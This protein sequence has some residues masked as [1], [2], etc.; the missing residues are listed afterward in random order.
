MACD[1]TVSLDDEGKVSHWHH[2]PSGEQVT[3]RSYSGRGNL[4]FEVSFRS[5]EAGTLAP[6]VWAVATDDKGIFFFPVIYYRER[7]EVVPE[8]VEVVRE[9]QRP[10]MA[11]PSGDMAD[12]LAALKAHLGENAVISMSDKRSQRQRRR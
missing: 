9:R 3:V 10:A 8:K 6:G 4:N 11:A 2:I 12:A 5:P 1:R 7:R